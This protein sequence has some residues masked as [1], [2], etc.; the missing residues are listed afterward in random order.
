MIHARWRERL[1]LGVLA[2]AAFV[3]AHDAIY[4]IL[5]GPA[6]RFGMA[7]LGHDG[8][9][10]AAVVI[11]AVLSIGLGMAGLVRLIQLARLAR[12]LDAGRVRVAAPATAY[13]GRHLVRSWIAIFPVATLLFIGVEN[14][15][16][17]A[18]GLPV[19]GLA[20]LGSLGYPGT[21]A[22]LGAVAGA[23]ALVEALY[24][25]RRDLL[26]ARIDAARARWART[27]SPTRPDL[28]WVERRHGSISGHTTIG[29][30]PPGVAA[31]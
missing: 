18:A 28:P 2:L 22:V 17:V 20:V 23:A 7:R 1:R 27:S 11:V 19:P 10:T 26:T 21:L 4:L 15:E 5:F 16:H 12:L 29:R 6:Y 31:A 13:L 30:A 3:L 14:V 8:R 25:W 9:W 24:R